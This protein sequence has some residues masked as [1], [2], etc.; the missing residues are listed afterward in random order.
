MHSVDNTS[1]I[2][3]SSHDRSHQINGFFNES[4]M[5]RTNNKIKTNVIIVN[6]SDGMWNFEEFETLSLCSTYGIHRLLPVAGKL[7][8]SAQSDVLVLN[9]NTLTV[10]VCYSRDNITVHCTGKMAILN[11]YR[12]VGGA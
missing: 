11:E 3:M 8:C 12:K 9:P 2:S 7:W 6:F 4:D 10:E 1:L 5:I